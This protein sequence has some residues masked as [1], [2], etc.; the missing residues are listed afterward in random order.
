MDIELLQSLQLFGRSAIAIL[1]FLMVFLGSVALLILMF[2][3]YG[4]V[5]IVRHFHEN[6]DAEAKGEI[7]ILETEKK[8]LEEEIKRLTVENQEYK[9]AK[10]RTLKIWNDQ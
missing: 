7:G 5:R 2:W 3:A 4:K 6:I 10:S 1:P 8:F 9:S